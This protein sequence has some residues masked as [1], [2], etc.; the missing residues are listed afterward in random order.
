MPRV[1]QTEETLSDLDA[2][3]RPL[4]IRRRRIPPKLFDVLCAHHSPLKF[5][6]EPEPPCTLQGKLSTLTIGPS[7][8]PPKYCRYS[9]LQDR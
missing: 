1:K 4:D 6:I 7:H 8:E 2:Y 3:C 9:D 5:D